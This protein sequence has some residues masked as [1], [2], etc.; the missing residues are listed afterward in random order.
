MN[1][2]WEKWTDEETKEFQDQ[3]IQWYEQEKRNLPWRYNR[4]P[5]RIWISEIMLQQTRVDTVIDYFYRFMEWFPTIE[6]LATAPEEKLLKAWEGLGYYSRAR[7]IQS[8]AKQIM[9]EFDGKMPQTPEE[10]SSLKGIGPYTTGAIASIAF[11]LPEPA[12]D[13]NVMRVVSRLFCIE[14]D[15]AKASS[16]KIFDEAM[17]KII[18]ETYPG[19]FNQS[20]M[21]LGSAICTPTS[22]KC[23]AC[24][25]Q[26]FCLANKR[27]IQT[28]FPVKTKKAK[29]KNVYYISAALQNHSGAYYFEERDSQ[30][31]LANM[32]TFPMVEVT[33]EEYERFKKEWEAKQEVDLFDDLVAEDGKELP[34]EKQELFIWQTRHLGEVTHVFSH[35]KWHVL[36]FYGRATEEAEQEFTENKTSKWL[37][38]AAFDSVVFPKVQMKLVEQ[39]EKNRNNRNPF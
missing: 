3:F 5:Y 15:I 38:P 7:N 24:P 30:K 37:K 22:P 27:G 31:L 11:G 32:W 17:R 23:E 19:E 20:M 39:L 2:E 35:L 14:A 33:Q 16:R 28:S 25:I 8:A 12:V 9:S 13:G 1:K 10:I 26:A 36:L 21:D 18:D 34:F 29:P 4:D 6:E